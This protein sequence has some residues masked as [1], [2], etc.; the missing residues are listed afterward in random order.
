M[1]QRVVLDLRRHVSG[2]LQGFMSFCGAP[3]SAVLFMGRVVCGTWVVRLAQRM[4]CPSATER[5]ILCGMQT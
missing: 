1:E 5:A 2:V 4:I 3:S